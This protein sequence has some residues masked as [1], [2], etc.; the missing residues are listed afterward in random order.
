MVKNLKKRMRENGKK[1]GSGAKPTSFPPSRYTKICC[2]DIT[3]KYARQ[4]GLFS[5]TP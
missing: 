2:V 5:P 4:D 3:Q 1:K